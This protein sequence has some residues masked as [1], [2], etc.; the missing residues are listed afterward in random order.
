[1]SKKFFFWQKLFF[2]TVTFEL[3]EIGIKTILPLL[4]SLHQDTSKTALELRAILI[5]HTV[6][7]KDNIWK[8][9]H[10]Q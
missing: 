6:V 9:Y 10:I 8:H 2:C 5:G 1:M 3:R 4:C 7:P